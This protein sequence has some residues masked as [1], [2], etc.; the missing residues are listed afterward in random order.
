MPDKTNMDAWLEKAIEYFP[1]FK[2]Y[3]VNINDP[4]DIYIK[5]ATELW[6]DLE[7]WFY[8]AIEREDADLQG[9]IIKFLRLCMSGEF[10]DESSQI[11][12]AIFCG[13]LWSIGRHKDLWH[14]LPRWFTEEEFKRYLPEISYGCTEDE[15]KQLTLAYG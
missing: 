9:R 8:V 11:Q 4:A 2:K 5:N 10:G 15:K 3:Y 13:F 6:L 12:Q 14:L 1:E 7:D